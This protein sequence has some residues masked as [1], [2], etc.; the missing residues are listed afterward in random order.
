MKKYLLTIIAVIMMTLSMKAQGGGQ[1]G[2]N[3]TY[4]F[5]EDNLLTR[6]LIFAPTPFQ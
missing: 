4:Y 5:D 2:D 6:S 1:C 3:L